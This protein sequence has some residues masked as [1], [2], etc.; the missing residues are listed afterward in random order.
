[1][2]QDYQKVVD[3]NLQLQKL[4]NAMGSILLTTTTYLDSLKDSADKVTAARHTASKGQL[5]NYI[6]TISTHMAE[7]SIKIK[8]NVE[9][10]K[11]GVIPE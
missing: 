4:L 11:K 3:A 2:T 5:T 6:L 1:M 9:S 10:I 8:D 7:A